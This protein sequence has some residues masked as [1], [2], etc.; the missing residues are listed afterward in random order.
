MTQALFLNDLTGENMKNYANM[1][2]SAF[3]GEE[4]HELDN[5]A[6]EGR[7]RIFAEGDGFFGGLNS[8]DYLSE[9]LDSPTWGEVF[10][11]SLKSQAKTLDLSHSYF[12]GF[13][14]VGEADGVSV[15]R[16]CLGS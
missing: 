15:L 7:C 16:L 12:E 6:F 13:R 2:Y 1:T 4:Y 11:H 3:D 5:V 14:K 9:I 8:Q 10:L